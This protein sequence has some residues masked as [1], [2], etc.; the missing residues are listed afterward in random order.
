VHDYIG[1]QETS[2]E[3]LIAEQR[4]L[5]RSKNP[6]EQVVG[7]LCTAALLKERLAAL[8]NLTI[9]Q[10]LTDQIWSQMNLLGPESVIVEIA[11]ERLLGSAIGIGIVPKAARVEKCETSLVCPECGAEFWRAK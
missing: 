3:D 2:V 6:V 7:S 8:P 11:S 9:S 5:A 4:R 1:E 10:L